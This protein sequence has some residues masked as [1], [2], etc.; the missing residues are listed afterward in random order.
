MGKLHHIKAFIMMPFAGA[1]IVPIILLLFVS[2]IQLGWDLE[3]PLYFLLII[4][5]CFLIGCGLL[6]MV[7]TT[8]LFYKVGKGTL[9]HWDPPKNLVAVGIY[10]NVRNPMVLGVVLTVFGEI[11]IF[12]AISLIVYFL[13]LFIGNHILFVKSE[14]PELI[15]RFGEDYIHY[16]KNVPRWIPRRKPWVD[17]HDEDSKIDKK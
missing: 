1:V 10:R 17:S 12:G 14:E 7:R 15:K 13:F 11:L 5:G 4:I 2:E 16:M 9:A 6:L 8:Y 3:S